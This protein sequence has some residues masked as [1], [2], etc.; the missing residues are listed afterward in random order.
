VFASYLIRNHKTEDVRTALATK[1]D[2]ATVNEVA[3][4]V[5]QQAAVLDTKA[6]GGASQRG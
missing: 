1:S 2:R 6:F 4:Q 3:K 5:Q